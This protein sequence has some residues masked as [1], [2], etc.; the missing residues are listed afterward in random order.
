MRRRYRADG[1]SVEQAHELASKDAEQKCRGDPKHESLGRE[2]NVAC[3]ETLTELLGI[4]ENLFQK[5]NKNRSYYTMDDLLEKILT[6]E[7]QPFEGVKELF[8]CIN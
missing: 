3:K 2:N 7:K 6:I 4:D 8:W 5:I 1:Y